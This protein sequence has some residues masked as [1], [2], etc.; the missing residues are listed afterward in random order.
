M[1]HRKKHQ[2]N[3]QIETYPIHFPHSGIT[4]I[5]IG[6][7]QSQ[8][9]RDYQ[10]DS[11]GYWQSRHQQ[12]RFAAVVADGMGGLTEGNKISA[13][14]VQQMLEQCKEMNPELPVMSQLRV[15]LQDMNEEAKERFPESGSTVVTVY[16][17]E[18]GLYWCCAGD[19]RIYL[20]RRGR[21]IQLN[22][23]DDYF[24]R[25]FNRVR[26]GSLTYKEAVAEPQKDCLVQ[27]VGMQSVIE[28]DCNNRPFVLEKHDKLLL[29]SDGIYNMLSR[30]ELIEIMAKPVSKITE[31]ILLKSKQNNNPYQDNFTAVILQFE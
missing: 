26:E 24:N 3:N 16:C 6:Y 21:L 23:D 11:F 19:S 31:S 10:E 1:K 5:V 27:Y 13:Y 18:N 8:G 2:K 12:K 14:V 20:Y 15:I 4:H 7:A 30:Q 17:D 28:P 25:L 29:C 9:M 22:E